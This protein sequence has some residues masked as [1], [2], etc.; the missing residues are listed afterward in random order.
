MPSILRNI[1]NVENLSQKKG[2]DK[3]EG[4]ILNVLAP[5]CPSSFKGKIFSK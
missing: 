1:K 4:N 5:L 2:V 3:F